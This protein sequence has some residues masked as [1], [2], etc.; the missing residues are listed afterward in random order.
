MA[1]QE[2]EPR[3]WSRISLRLSIWYTSIFTV[4]VLVIVVA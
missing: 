3:F 4:S 2:K 1:E